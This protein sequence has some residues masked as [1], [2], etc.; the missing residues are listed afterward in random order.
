MMAQRLVQATRIL[1]MFSLLLAAGLGVT[2][3]AQAEDAEVLKNPYAEVNWEQVNQYKANLHS[4]TVKSDGRA[5]PEELI[6]NYAEAGYDVLAITDHDNYHTTREGE[7]ETTPTTDTTWPWTEWI[8]EEP[9]E[10]WERE[11][12]ETSAFYPDLGESGMLAIRGNEL[13][14]HPHIASLFNDCGWP[15]RDQTDDERMS[16]VQDKNAIAYWAHPAIYVPGGRWEDNVVD[17]SWDEAV[18][19][20]AHYITEYDCLIGIEMQ[21]GGRREREEELLDRLLAEYYRDHDVFIKGSDDTHATSVAEDATL[22]IVLAEELTDDAMRHAL[23]NGH[24]FVGSR[25]D[26]LPV[27]NAITVDEDAKVISLDIDNHEG[28]VWIANGERNHEGES[29]EY[30]GMEDTVLRF[31]V[32]AGGAVFYSQAF[33]ID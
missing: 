6:Y 31:E 2:V 12:M 10:T 29:I 20:F 32:D 24:N 13:T 30:A 5:L 14:T 26:V 7:P 22:T 17:A 11:G 9:S 21:L 15:D 28:I 3:L 23:E 4:H 8:E 27:F 1:V 25:V 16:C 18:E 33:Y 19:Y